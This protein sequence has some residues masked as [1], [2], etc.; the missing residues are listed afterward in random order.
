MVLTAW[1]L[2]GGD[3]A[4]NI[5]TGHPWQLHVIDNSVRGPDGTKLA[6]F[7]KD[8]L[9]DVVTAWETEGVTRVYLHPGYESVKKPWPA[10]TI[11]KTRKA[12]DALP[13]DL[14]GDGSVDVVTSC[15]IKQYDLFVHWGPS[16]PSKLLDP[17]AWKQ[18]SFPSVHDKTAW[19]Y[20]EPISLSA[21]ALPD[22]VVGGK[23]KLKDEPSTLGLLIAPQERRNVANYAFKPLAVINWVMSIEV[24]D[25]DHDGDQ[26][27]LYSDKHGPTAGAWWLENPGSRSDALREEWKNHRLTPNNYESTSFLRSGDVDRDGLTDIVVLADLPERLFKTK[28]EKR[29]ITILRRRDDRGTSWESIELPVPPSTGQPKGIGLADLNDDG[30]VDLILTSTG[31]EGPE[32]GAYWLEQPES[33]R[34]T[35]WKAHNISGPVGIKYDHANLVDLDGDGDLDLL[36]TEEKEGATGLGVIW[37]ENPLGTGK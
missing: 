36:S 9:P 10:V 33:L 31:A 8:G 27:I 32:I 12:E 2:H 25:F 35:N 21:G 34:S 28:L 13:I 15:E 11:G 4:P 29:R 6:D 20:A 3:N 17:N 19:M 18:E 16:D 26:D 23:G 7:N 37:Y 1:T 30:R 24:Y 22:L 5:P 14:D